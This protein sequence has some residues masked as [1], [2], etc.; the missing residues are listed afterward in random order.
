MDAMTITTKHRPETPATTVAAELS[1]APIVRLA[2]GFWASKALLSAVE[3]GVFTALAATPLDGESLRR[4]L[5]I[6]QRGARDFFDALVALGLLERQDGV[7][8]NSPA[9]D[10]YLD[11]NKRS[12]VGG[13]IEHLNDRLYPAWGRLTEALRTGKPQIDVKDG[14]EL[15]DGYDDPQ[16]AA[17][18]ARAMTGASLPIARALSHGFQWR[19]F[20]TFVDIGTAEGALPVEI[21]RAHP[22]LR[23]GGFDLAPVRPLFEAYVA[24][25]GLSDRLHF[26]AGDFLNG[27]LPE[28]DVLVMGHILHD[29]TVEVKRELL[30][31]AYAALPSDG[32]LIVYDQMI[33]DERRAHAP[34]L[35]MSLNMLLATQGGFDYTAADCIAWMRQS[36]F[37]A[38][39][40][41]P[42]CA[43]YTMVIGVK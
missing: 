35:L 12:Y 37:P 22:H 10:L 23:G 20:E 19:H 9:A 1:P 39:R 41:A 18:F 17:D 4:Q 2:R 14:E 5:R 25:H 27:P 26:H 33:D 42:L 43:P 3:L 38:A 8:S 24:R 21:A 30:V 15:F 40:R 16:V 32:A 6:D 13:L 34:G 31:K 28:A 29:W 7:Y 36:G 11:H